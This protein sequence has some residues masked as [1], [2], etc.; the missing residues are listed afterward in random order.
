M[1]HLS[2]AVSDGRDIEAAIRELGDAREIAKSLAVVHR[3]YYLSPMF[4]GMAFVCIITFSIPIV[5]WISHFEFEALSAAI[6]SVL[7][8]HR[9]I[10][11]KDQQSLRG[12]TFFRAHGKDRDAG[13]FLNPK[14]AWEIGSQSESS[15][16]I[17]SFLDRPAIISV[18]PAVVKTL[19]NKKKDWVALGNSGID[20]SVDLAWM[21]KLADYD[22]WDNFS[23]EPMNQ[24]MSDL[25][26]TPW[27]SFPLPN[28]GVMM[29]F[30]KIRLLRGMRTHQMLLALK[31]VRQLAQLV[32]S[33]ETLIGSMTSV[34][35]LSI[36]REAYGQALRDHLIE[37]SEWTPMSEETTTRA[38]RSLYA[39]TELFQFGAIEYQL[40]ETLKSTGGTAGYCSA[41]AEAAVPALVLRDQLGEQIYPL[42]LNLKDRFSKME[43]L[44]SDG[45]C[46][47]TYANA[48]RAQSGVTS[49]WFNDIR[50]MSFASNPTRTDKLLHALKW[51]TA[52]HVPWIR[53]WA[54][55]SF[56]KAALPD[57]MSGPYARNQLPGDMP[58]QKRD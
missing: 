24:V 11:L 45:Q 39:Y 29:N 36:E 2:E 9:N 6:N 5:T 3:A 33:N 56:Q 57:F 18:P 46:R 21:G 58:E 43:K 38:R 12:E 14:I 20:S 25:R 35:I 47:L 28:Y 40:L 49:S 22:H 10:F 7:D 19:K 53:Q 50:S 37:G 15:R 1:D 16:K 55:F 26:E 42:E 52:I 44:I 48:M 17:F 4:L 8:K 23:W 31:E 34:A 54:L 41:L 51:H 30:A 32:Y 27:W 13:P